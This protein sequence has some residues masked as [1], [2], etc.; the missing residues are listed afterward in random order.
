MPNNSQQIARLLQSLLRTSRGKLSIGWMVALLVLVG[1]YLI[2]EPALEARLGFDLPGVN[3]PSTSVTDFETA[4]ARTESPPIA[5]P[6]A[7][8]DKGELAHLLKEI[9]RDTF[10]SPA[11][12]VYARGSQHGH[13]LKHLMAH[14]RDEPD[15]P[16]Q[17]GVF[18]DTDTS[19][20]V[21]LIDEAYEQAL[22]GKQTKKSTESKRTI[23]TVNLGRSIG[24]I[25]GQS[26]G[27]RG[28]PNA[29]HI[30]LVLEGK[31]FITAFPVIP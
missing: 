6:K 11:G 14:A 29:S 22:S 9:G 19:E 3:S 12:I 2:F 28:H 20:V 10:E 31:K 17:H 8:A 21:K 4:P 5:P 7:N 16:G 25:G 18:D 15:R 27:R 23:Y 24:T 26:G 30:R 1:A 13:R